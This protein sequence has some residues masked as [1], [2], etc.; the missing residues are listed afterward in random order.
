MLAAFFFPGAGE[1]GVS[2]AESSATTPIRLRHSEMFAADHPFGR[3]AA[4]WAGEVERATAQQVRIDISFAGTLT[5]P[6]ACFEGVLQGLSDICHTALAYTPGRFPVME[7]ADLPGYSALGNTARLTS[8]V[9]NALYRTF[10]PA[11]FAGVHVLY[12]HAHPPGVITSASRPIHH[13]ED[14]AGLRFR[15]TGHSAQ[16]A[17][18]LGAEPVSG[19]AAETYELL[20][21][22]RVDATMATLESLKYNRFAD[23]ARFTAIA[24]ELGYV[25]T[26]ALVIRQEVWETLPAPIRDAITAVSDAFAERAAALWDRINLEGFEY[27]L[28]R[29]HEFTVLPAD[30]VQEWARLL[31]RELERGYVERL[32]PLGIDGW[33]V[34]ARRWAEIVAHLDDFAPLDLDLER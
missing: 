2:A 23:A 19:R 11:E 3:L 33:Q 20:R 34:L 16:I 15:S 32:R 25:T 22:N 7:A 29:G 6:Q 21:S 27:A 26:F 1:S 14:L 17:T 31:Q 10:Q 13:V 30:E 18:L 5:S 12:L 8:A 28:E 24:P 4:E 9:A